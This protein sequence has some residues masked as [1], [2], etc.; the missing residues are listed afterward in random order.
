MSDHFQDI[1]RRHAAL[2]DRM[3]CCE[4][5]EGNIL[6]ALQSIRALDG[7]DVVEFGAGTGRLTRLLL[8]CV[9]LVC[10]FDISPHMLETARP[11]LE[12]LGTHWTLAVADN[13]A[14]PVERGTADMTIAGWS[15]GHGTAWYGDSW[16]D[17]IGRMVDE[18]LRVLKPD[19]TAIVIETMGTGNEVPAPPGERLAAYYH[20]LE[21][22]R[23]F[24]CTWIRTDYQF[25]SVEEADTL[26]RFFFGDTLGDRI[27]REQM[28]VL[29]ECTG[30]WWK[31]G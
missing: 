4:D 28:T 12:R 10:A 11:S 15:F 25:T 5:Y 14:M 31:H 21:T 3:V 1:Y 17:E 16:L 20:W 2:Y 24:S 18:L 19:G 29:P 6:P 8:P 27:V 22:R 7:L 26:T 9:R 13:R 30:I 23:G